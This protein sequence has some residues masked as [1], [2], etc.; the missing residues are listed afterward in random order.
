M[1]NNIFYFTVS[2]QIQTTASNTVVEYLRFA[3]LSRDE[4]VA[5]IFTRSFRL[6]PRAH[7]LKYNP[8]TK[9]TV[10]IEIKV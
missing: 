8:H 9:K 3:P 4:N 10:L 2:N 7:S 6:Q 1:E 5:Y